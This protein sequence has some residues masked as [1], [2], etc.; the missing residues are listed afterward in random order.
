M[1]RGGGGRG[2][3]R[4]GGGPREPAPARFLLHVAQDHRTDPAAVL[5]YLEVE[6]VQLQLAAGKLLV[7]AESQRAFAVVDELVDDAS[8]NLPPELVD[9]VHPVQHVF[10]LRT[11]QDAGV[12]RSPDTTRQLRD[13]RKVVQGGAA[14]P[15]RHSR[16]VRQGFER[17]AGF[18]RSAPPHSTSA[19]TVVAWEEE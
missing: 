12:V 7:S 19:G 16:T 3:A 8:G 15:E 9:V 1:R 5:R 18:S 13:D 11:G 17:A 14:D 2:R 10:D 4:A 6:F